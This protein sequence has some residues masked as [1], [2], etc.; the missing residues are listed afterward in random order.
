MSEVNNTAKAKTVQE[1]L[2]ELSELVAW[3][4]SPAF[5]LE[6]AV[7]KLKKISPSLKMILKL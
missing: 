2:T 3:F 6:D 7:T 1:K 4:Q 5:K